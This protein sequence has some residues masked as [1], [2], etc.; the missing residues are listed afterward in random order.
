MMLGGILTGYLFRKLSFNWISGLITV[1]IWILLF[2]LGIEVGSNESIISNL[3][4]LGLEALLLATAA[5][6]GSV[7]LASLLWKAVLRK[8]G[9]RQDGSNLAKSSVSAQD[10]R[11]GV[12]GS[13]VIVGFF[14]CGTVLGLLA[15]ISRLPFELGRI[16]SAVL[17]SLM[18]CVG[19]SIGRDEKTLKS[20]RSINPLFMLLPVMT[21]LGTWIGAALCAIPLGERSISD[22]LAVG[23]GLGYYSLSSVLI[24]EAKGAD[25]GTIA[26]LSNIIREIFALVLAPLILRFFGRLAPISAGGCTTADTTLPIITSVCG[27]EFAVVSIYHGFVTDFLVP[28]MVT[29]FC[30]F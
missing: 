27:K 18:F 23:S 25:L 4:T 24:T 1:L 8:T 21:I 15:D 16:S 20:F 14:A 13:L 29:L 12:K 5:T 22:C 7:F 11:N 19:I 26:L 30:A 28:F 3:G 17:F 10:I 2:V 6:L 9:D